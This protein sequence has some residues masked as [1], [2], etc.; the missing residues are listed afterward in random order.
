MKS[1]PENS[2]MGSLEQNDEELEP[3]MEADI[4][5]E[6]PG[7]QREQDRFDRLNPPGTRAKAM[8]KLMEMMDR[9]GK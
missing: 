4:P 7:L 3:G 9:K 8:L 6:D 2:E 1:Q 5:S